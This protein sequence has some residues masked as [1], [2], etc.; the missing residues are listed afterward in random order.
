MNSSPRYAVKLAALVAVLAWALTPS[1]A[2]AVTR[3]AV[4]SRGERWIAV[5]VPYSQ[6]RYA[7]EAGVRVSGSSLGWRTDCS[8]F[9]SMCLGLVNSDGTP[10]S[11]DTAT[12]PSKLQR[13]TKADLKPG[14]IILRPKNAT[15]N[16]QPVP[17]GHA[18]V[19]VRWVD[20]SKTTYVGYHES[21]SKNG[22]VAAEIGYPFFGE[23]GFA[24]YR[25]VQIE[26]ARLRKSRTWFGGLAPVTGSS[27]LSLTAGGTMRSLALTPSL[28][29]T[30][31]ATP[32]P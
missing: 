9:V 22:A 28:G 4:L 3:E 12:L 18:V 14:D 27:V 11:L 26:D 5:K 10:R 6:S 21:S 20:A 17:Y 32:A 15:V 2:L 13:I 25:Y 24:P 29:A 30:S 8:G 23:P 19:F 1:V 7:D 16:G 31:F